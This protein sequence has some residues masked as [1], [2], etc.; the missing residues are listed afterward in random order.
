MKA[1]VLLILMGLIGC[2]Q[3]QTSLG[4][5][6][7]FVGDSSVEIRYD[8]II[9]S[10]LP[11]SVEWYITDTAGIVVDSDN[12]LVFAGSNPSIGSYTLYSMP[13]LKQGNLYH[14]S[15]TFGSVTDTGS[16]VTLGGTTNIENPSFAKS[17]CTINK[18]QGGPIKVYAPV[19]ALGA[20]IQIQVFNIL[21][22]EKKKVIL[23]QQNETLDVSDLST[24]Y[25][26]VAVKDRTSPLVTKRVYVE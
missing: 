9:S 2:A 8:S 10:A 25:Y 1:C 26:I 19:E 14:W 24:G 3:A 6:Q 12:G 18:V 13:I 4:E 7:V 5:P 21:G 20:T 11:L 15:I 22:Q 16:F 17:A 23:T